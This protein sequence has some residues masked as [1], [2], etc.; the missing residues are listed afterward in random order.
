VELG[1]AAG[2]RTY[3]GGMRILPSLPPDEPSQLA[4]WQA[5]WRSGQAFL[6][7]SWRELWP[8]ALAFGLVVP[9]CLALMPTLG[10]LAAIAGLAAL[11]AS[12]GMLAGLLWL[13]ASGERAF[14]P[15]WAG[16]GRIWRAAAG[17]MAAL[18]LG[19]TAILGA[20]RLGSSLVGDVGTLMG[21][22]L[23]II[24]WLWAMA[25]AWSAAPGWLCG[26]ARPIAWERGWGRVP[27]LLG[28]LTPAALPLLPAAALASALPGLLGILA[29]STGVTAC[30]IL[31][32]LGP[33]GAAT[34]FPE[35]LGKGSSRNPY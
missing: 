21:A 13:H 18:A 30:L 19:V 16:D 12:A 26:E 32:V 14:W 27:R 6:S 10:L 1:K 25:S 29:V 31:L 9:L 5:A 33:A 8:F 17:G 11:G 24:A 22:T 2:W 15:A 28:C 35:G 20:A 34:A 23:G 3:L 7:D 4:L